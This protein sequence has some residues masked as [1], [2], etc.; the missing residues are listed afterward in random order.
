M[1]QKWWPSRRDWIT[2][3]SFIL[4]VNAIA[5][6]YVNA[7]PEKSTAELLLMINTFCFN[8]DGNTI[9]IINTIENQT[10]SKEVCNLA[11]NHLRELGYNL[12]ITTVVR[13]GQQENKTIK[14]Y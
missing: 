5:W 11:I 9:Q 14:P 6:V 13:N 10:K 4:A 7:R 3:I 12:T 1:D 8:G 2:I